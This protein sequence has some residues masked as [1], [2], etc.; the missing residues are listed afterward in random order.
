[1]RK[2]DI[3][4]GTSLGKSLS[5]STLLLCKSYALCK[6]ISRELSFNGYHCF[7]GTMIQCS[8]LT[9]VIPALFV[10]FSFFLSFCA[11]ACVRVR[12]C[13]CVCVSE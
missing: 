13:V 4:E 3:R 1:M 6:K 12:V 7:I 8:F 2:T 5:R 10:S 11:C 9:R